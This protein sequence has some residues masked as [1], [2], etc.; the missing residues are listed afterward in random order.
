M[1]SM[2]KAMARR[3]TAAV[4]AWLLA[5]SV[6]GAA[7]GPDP[8]T[9]F[10]LPGAWQEK[11]WSEPG[12]KGLL[13]LDA[14]KLA[15]L[16]PTQAGLRH[17]RC[18]GCGASEAED[19]LA[20][21][22][23]KPDVVTCR[24]CGLAVPNEKFPAEVDKKIPEEAVEVLPGV[25][26]KYPY[27]A[28]DPEKQAY[29]D[30]RLYLAA[31]RDYE[32]R[33]YLAKAALYAAV[34][35]RRPPAGE[36]DPRYARLASIVLLRFAQV[37][38]A[39]AT[40]CDQAGEPKSFQRADLPPPYRRGYQT[41]KWD[42]SGALDVPINLAIAYA[43]LRGDPALHEAGRTLDDPQP[44]RTIERDLFRR[45]AEFV[46]HQPEEFSESSLY[47]YRGLLAVGRLLD[48]EALLRE[49]AARLDAFTE[50]GFYHDGLWRQGDAAAHRR[51]VAMLDGWIDRLMPG[52]GSAPMLDL[53]RGAAGP[54]PA[55]RRPTEIRLAGWPESGAGG[56][57]LDWSRGPALFGGASVARLSVGR[58]ADALDLEVGGPGDSGSGRHNRLALRLAVGGRAVLDDLDDRPPTA[59]GWDR[60]TV[61]HN[62]A[63]V[64][65]LNQRESLEQAR[66]PA[67][68][69]GSDVLFF[70]AEP[71]IQVATLEDR[72]AYPR[73]STRYRQTIVAAAGA[74][75]RY[76]VSVFEVRGGLQH[77]QF[78]HAAAGLPARWR[79]TVALGPGPGSLLPPAMAYVP[80]ARAED[81]RWF[82]QSYGA[83]G[84]LSQGR[85]DRP[86]QAELA[87]SG[88]PGVRLHLLGDAPATVLAGTSPDP[89][90][91]PADD[92]GRAAL[93]LRRRSENGA[94]LSTAFVTLFEPLTGQSSG[95]LRVGRV[96][97]PAE[98]VVLMIQGAE[99]VEHLVINLSP[100]KPLAVRLGDGQGLNTDGLAVRVTDQSLVLAGGTFAEV[101]GRRV[102]QS[103][104]SGTIRAADRTSGSA[105]SLGWFEAE[106]SP[107]ADDPATLAGR[108]LLIRH[109]DGTTRGWTLRAAEPVAPNRLRLHVREEPGFRLDPSTG[110][111][112]YYQFPR[113]IVPGPH[114]FW[115]AKIARGGRAPGG[116]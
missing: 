19:T 115:V 59:D 10:D 57:A 7:E 67:P 49:A 40:H 94:A 86:F 101:P 79:T 32:A 53:A 80:N 56:G 58:G 89:S 112:R 76:A 47:A 20:W 81:G 11:F 29:P 62:A 84:G 46:R 51:V 22:P 9:R 65:G 71:D 4:V 13:E 99:G 77:D 60:A 45:S 52:R 18:P 61:S 44:S 103:R 72:Y 42:W 6:V 17:C 5:G 2:R 114:R 98:A 82:V 12:A 39:Y 83:F 41:A 97:S 36:A 70:A 102:E 21:S 93:I 33:E 63:T 104:T 55:D 28:V 23:A 75:T 54:T 27:H 109:G 43:L 107:S 108:V 35:H 110:A 78:F 3:A 31:K 15:A 85:A 66:D 105:S 73:S 116:Q 8:L 96:A 25:W 68:I 64:D 30:E 91:S 90:R 95:P 24:K 69:P 88:A 48:D 34:R 26:H 16:V 1:M 74:T 38:P 50:R 111:A 14:K 92:P 106:T 37:Y 100:G 113:S 87:P